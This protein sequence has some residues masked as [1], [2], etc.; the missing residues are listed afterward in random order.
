MLD[1]DEIICSHRP[2]LIKNVTND[3]DDVFWESTATSDHG[4]NPEMNTVTKKKGNDNKV[5]IPDTVTVIMNNVACMPDDPNKD[6]EVESTNNSP[7]I[8]EHVL[9]KD[10]FV[11]LS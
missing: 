6:T 9:K 4:E 2:V 11:N 8:L 5:V 3:N 7:D 1:A 10:G